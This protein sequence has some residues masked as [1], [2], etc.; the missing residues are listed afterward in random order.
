VTRRTARALAREA[1]RRCRCTQYRNWEAV[2][3]G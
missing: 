2:A 1:G 3:P